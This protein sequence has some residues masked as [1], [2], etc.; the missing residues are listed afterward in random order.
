VIN[1]QLRDAIPNRLGIACVHKRQAPD[2][3]INAGADGSVTQTI[4]LFG[5]GLSLLDLNH[6][7][8]YPM[9]NTLVKLDL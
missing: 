6:V 7:Q 3:D 8:V 1:S 5:I 4:E 2:A 9:R